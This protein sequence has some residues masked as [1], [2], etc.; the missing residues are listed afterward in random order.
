MTWKNILKEKTTSAR[1]TKEQKISDMGK[2]Y[3]IKDLEMFFRTYQYVGIL[4]KK[5]KTIEDLKERVNLRR[6]PIKNPPPFNLDYLSYLSFPHV[7]LKGNTPEEKME[8]LREMEKTND[9]G[10][11]LK[12]L[13]HD[14]SMKVKEE[15][16]RMKGE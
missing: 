3:Q 8:T 16:D 14:A 7:E 5:A 9:L 6:A 10:E 11:Q 15:I 12:K 1:P 13:F 4:V 2:K